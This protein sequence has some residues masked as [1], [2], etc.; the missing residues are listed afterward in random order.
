[1][2]KKFCQFVFLVF[3]LACQRAQENLSLKSRAVVFCL[4]DIGSTGEYA[5]SEEQFLDFLKLLQPYPVLSLRDWKNELKSENPLPQAV[6]LTFDD[7]YPS[8]LSQVVPRLLFFGYGA[9]FYIYLNRHSDHSSFYRSLSQLGD[10]FELGSH[11]LSHGELKDFNEKKFFKEIY[12][13]RLKLAYLTGKKVESFAWPYG[14]FD[15]TYANLPRQAG[16]ETQVSTEK[17][18]AHKKDLDHIVPRFTLRR[19][20]ALEEAKAALKLLE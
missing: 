16:Y 13:S 1:M 15:P 5:L 18:L 7:G 20:H 11:S 2:G 6:V 14:S 10:R 4:H 17:R 3:F 12:H 8:L 9:T 19:A